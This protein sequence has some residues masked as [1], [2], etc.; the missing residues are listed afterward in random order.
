M[1]TTEQLAASLSISARQVKRL[2]AAGLPMLRVGA[3]AVRYD[4]AAC[5]AWLAGHGEHVAACLSTAA[6]LGAMKS[7]S[8]SV[9]SDFTAACRRA[10]LRVTPS[11]QSPNSD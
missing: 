2:Q 11:A 3:R 5:R 1:L 10:Q 4:E 9:A 8:A 7:L 6:P